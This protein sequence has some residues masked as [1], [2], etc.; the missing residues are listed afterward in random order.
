[1]SDQKIDETIHYA[2]EH[3]SNVADLHRIHD[4]TSHESIHE[5]MQ[6]PEMRAEIASHVDAGLVPAVILRRQEYRR[7][8]PASRSPIS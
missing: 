7:S 2:N 1:M 6:I 3:E 8:I 5:L 4:D